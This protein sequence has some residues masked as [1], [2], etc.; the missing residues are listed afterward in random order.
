MGDAGS[1]NSIQVRGF[2]YLLEVFPLLQR[3]RES[4][5][6]RDSAGNRELFF[7]QYVALVL[8]ALFSPSVD[9]M[10]AICRAS[11]LKKVQKKLGVKQVSLGS[12]SESSH[13]FDPG[14]LRGVIDELIGKLHPAGRDERLKDI[15]HL[16]TIVDATLLKALPKMAAAMWADNCDG[17]KR[18]AWKLHTQF[19]ID[20]HV[21]TRID[22][23]SPLNG[24]K[25]DEAA[26]LR[27]N[28][29]PDRCYVMDRYFGQF[30]LFNQI[31][32]IGSSYVCRVRDN[33]TFEVKQE[34]LL[35][36]EALDAE[37]VR[38]AIVI[39]GTASK[40]QKRPDHPV[41][42]VQIECT[43]HEKRGGRKGKTAGPPARETLIIATDQID[44]P[45]EVIALIYRYRWTI[46]IFF[47]FLKH[48]LGCRHL[49]SQHPNGVAIQVYCAIIACMLL[50][51][52]SGG[53][54]PTKPTLEM[55]AWYF[56]GWADE[57]ELERHLRGL[58]KNPA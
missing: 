2:K 51:L 22:V 46:E 57:E 41:R 5:C 40:P 3:L 27:Q 4:G 47:R 42:I 32:A 48:L 36:Q 53:A 55:F 33:S 31:H 52:W 49:F 56:S 14:L 58:Q 50:N 35:S 43:P 6:A 9:S 12:F 17:S 24:G 34:R 26:V 29:E 11:A 15:K 44:V 1:E 10:R 30:A 8:V 16:L 19:E 54:K 38:D 13:L 45:A 21:P 18:F 20:K 28:L 37:V 39:L 7:D 23:T 25:G